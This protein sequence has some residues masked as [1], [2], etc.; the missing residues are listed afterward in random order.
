VNAELGP[1]TLTEVTVGNTNRNRIYC[2]RQESPIIEKIG[3]SRS[4]LDEIFFA[5]LPF[6]HAFE[7]E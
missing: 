2:D 1:G 7:H 3:V 4:D 6:Q 5:S